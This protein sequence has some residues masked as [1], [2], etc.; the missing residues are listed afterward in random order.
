MYHVLDIVAIRNV[1]GEVSVVLQPLHID[2]Y[3]FVNNYFNFNDSI[4]FL[5]KAKSVGQDL[6]RIPFEGWLANV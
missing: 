6:A 5:E 4:L 3:T 2:L 1:N